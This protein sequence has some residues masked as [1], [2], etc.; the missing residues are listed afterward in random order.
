MAAFTKGN[1]AK[2]VMVLVGNDPYYANE[3]Y[4]YNPMR[5]GGKLKEG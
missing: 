4:R 5:R 1:H 2:C 3:N